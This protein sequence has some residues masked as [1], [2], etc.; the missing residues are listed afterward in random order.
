MFFIKIP[1]IF[2]N[3]VFLSQ[4]TDSSLSQ[5]KQSPYDKSEEQP[6]MT[7]LS[8]PLSDGLCQFPHPSFRAYFSLLDQLLPFVHLDLIS[9]RQRRK[10]LDNQR[11][12]A[13]LCYAGF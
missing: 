4:I 12:S 13:Q 10:G 7:H 8:S 3:T 2:C 1:S 5:V 6:R 11:V 9:V